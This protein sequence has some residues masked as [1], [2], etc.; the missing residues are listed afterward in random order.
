MLYLYAV[1][2]T[3]LAIVAEEIDDDD[4]FFIEQQQQQ[5]NNRPPIDCPAKDLKQEL[6]GTAF[7]PSYVNM[8][9]ELYD[10]I[11]QTW[12]QSEHPPSECRNIYFEYSDQANKTRRR[13]P[14][15]ISDPNRIIQFL[16]EMCESPRVWT[17]AA[18]NGWNISSVSRDFHHMLI[19]FCRTFGDDWIT[20]M[21][22]TQRT[23]CQG[24]WPNYPTAY[25]C[26][27]GSKYRRRKTKN[28]PPGIERKMYYDWKHKMPEAIDVQAVCNKFGLCTELLTGGPGSMGDA[29]LSHYVCNNDLN[30][31]TLVDGTYAN[32]PQFI[33][34]DGS[35]EHKQARV[36][37]EWLF[38]RNKL[39]WS[40][41]GDVYKRASRWHNLAI[42]AA[43]TL[44]N[45]KR[46]W[47]LNQRS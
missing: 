5:Y 47:Y 11:E 46:V 2:L 16:H 44:S 7:F 31:S 43:F 26:L 21:S 10:Y 37:V 14:C 40:M 41:T 3:L 38:G 15:K 12:M 9:T 34:P 4:Y 24:L 30:G 25:Q 18:S 32:R 35:I 20:P 8:P 17:S 33:K 6:Y 36:C 19:Q 27:D 42:R 45:M 39:S 28:L 13:R 29:N 1:L 22:A 23:N